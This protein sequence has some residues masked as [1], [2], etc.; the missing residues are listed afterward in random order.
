[1]RTQ[2]ADDDNMGDIF[3]SHRKAQQEKRRENKALSTTRV[4]DSGVPFKSH[5]DGE[6]LILAGRWDFWPSTGR[7]IE[8][9]GIAGKAKRQG[10]GVF[11]LL[12]IIQAESK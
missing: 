2:S 4:R 11:N 6:H 9:K 5:N 7:Y 8:R 1:M 3:R 12:S 10:R